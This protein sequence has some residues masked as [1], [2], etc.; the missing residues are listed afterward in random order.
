ML[1]ELKGIV[2]GVMG[3]IGLL[4]VLA[5]FNVWSP[6]QA[7]DAT[8]VGVGVFSVLCGLYAYRRL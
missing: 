7:I 8:K 6:E 2:G 1:K 4:L 5:G 3:I